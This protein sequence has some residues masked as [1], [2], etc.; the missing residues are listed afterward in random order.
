VHR[1]NKTIKTY[2]RNPQSAIQMKNNYTK[3]LLVLMMALQTAF[4]IS[5]EKPN[6]PHNLTEAEKTLVSEF[7]FTSPRISQPPS[8]PVRAA[9]EW[10]EVEYLL[11]TWQPAYPNILRQIVQAGVQEC[12]VIIT[13]QNE[14]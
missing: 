2:L 7:Q 13:T 9:A 1:F 4:A 11:V 5:Q 6:L 10:E 3:Y 14:A 8:G 12:K